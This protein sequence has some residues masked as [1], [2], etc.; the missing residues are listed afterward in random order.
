MLNLTNGDGCTPLKRK[1]GRMG[2]VTS[3]KGGGM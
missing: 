1:E 3:E 2:G